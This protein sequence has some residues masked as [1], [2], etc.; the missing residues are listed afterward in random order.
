MTDLFLADTSALIRFYRGQTGPAW[1][2]AVSSGAVGLCEP[3]RQEFLRATGG[4]SAYFEA[5]H[6]L[7]ETFPYYS[8]RDSVWDDCADL[9]DRLA[10]RSWHQCAS[11]IDLLVA[12]TAQHHGL[13]VLHAD[14]DFDAIAR[15]TGQ[16]VRRIT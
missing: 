3:V 9:R 15:I 12:V 16:E 10:N 13:I 8:M 7:R 1:D 6:M 2:T 14:H 4:R 5:A 11:A